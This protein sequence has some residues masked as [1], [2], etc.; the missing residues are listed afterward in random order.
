MPLIDS[1]LP[2]ARFV[3][4]IRDGRDVAISRR[5]L[6]FE[7]GETIE[8]IARVWCGEV[9]S[10]R[11]GGRSVRHYLEVRYEDLVTA[12]ES[13]LRRICDFVELRFEPA[14]LRYHEGATA[15]LG[16]IGDRLAR[17]GTVRS[18]REQRLAALESSTQPPDAGLAGRWRRDMSEEDRAEFE[19]IAGG[20]LRE[21]G[22][23]IA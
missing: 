9:E 16:E 18:T 19:R 17:D 11:S 4:L 10:A 3:H 8:E 6:W 20:L 12:P 22:Y 13:E 1:L 5:G 2:E 14:M 15:R 23:E 7:G 21:L